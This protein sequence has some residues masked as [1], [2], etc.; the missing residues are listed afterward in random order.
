MTRMQAI[1]VGAVWAA[2]ALGA[3]A[4]GLLVD[5]P[6]QLTVVTLLMLGLFLA[7]GAGQLL[8]G[9]SRGFI[10]RVTLATVGALLILAVASAIMG[11]LGAG[12]H[13]GVSAG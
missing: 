6:R 7:A 4:I 13:V 11:V 8:S 1:G 5:R 9:D 3:L 2:A 12:G 10:R